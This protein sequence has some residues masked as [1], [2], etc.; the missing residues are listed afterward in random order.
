M[1]GRRRRPLQWLRPLF[2]HATRN[3]SGSRGTPD[4]RRGTR[5]QCQ[6]QG[7]QRGRKRRKIF[8]TDFFFINPY[9]KGIIKH[10]NYYAYTDRSIS[11]ILD[12]KSELKYYRSYFIGKFIVALFGRISHLRANSVASFSVEKVIAW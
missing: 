1:S 2:D 12:E 3:P 7:A 9:D 11:N 6:T 5:A 10:I 4:P 8:L